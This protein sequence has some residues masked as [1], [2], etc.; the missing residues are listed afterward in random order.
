[1]IL[2]ENS[3]TSGANFIVTADSTVDF[4]WQNRT[5]AVT[6]TGERNDKKE[7]IVH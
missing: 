6:I 1:M 3:D 5:S 2:Y 4:N 7:C